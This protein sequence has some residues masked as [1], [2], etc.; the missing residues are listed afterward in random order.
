VGCAVPQTLAVGASFTCSYA[1]IAIDGTVTNTATASSAETG[2][3]SDSATVVGLTRLPVL[4]IT[5]GASL[6][7]DGPFLERLDVIRG[8]LVRYRITVANAGNVTLTGITLA[9]N[10]SS[11]P[12]CAV[13]STLAVG[14]SFSCRYAAIAID[15][16]LVNTAT[17]SSIETGPVSDSATVVGYGG[18]VRD[19]TTGR[20]RITKSFNTGAGFPGGTFSF[21]VSC[22][23]RTVS[24]TVAAGSTS[25]S[26]LIPDQVLAGT[27]CTVTELAPLTSAGTGYSWTGLPVYLPGGAGAPSSTVLI[28]PGGEVVVTVTNTRQQTGVVVTPPPS[29]SPPSGSPPS[30]SPPSGSPPSGSPGRTLR[31]SDSADPVPPGTARADLTGVLVVLA[32]LLTLVVVLTPTPRR[33]RRRRDGSRRAGSW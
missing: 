11:L 7:V 8:Q 17:A 21:Y 33:A 9:D 32:G 25:G 27:S 3:V 18:D 15:G 5:K 19:E 29:G 6:S 22:L 26:V 13:P 16:A 10:R 31:P 24:V 23:D 12:G 20:L 30:G 2:P 4:T 14:A 1:A 28:P